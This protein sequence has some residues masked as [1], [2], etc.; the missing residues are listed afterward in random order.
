MQRFRQGFTLIELL[1]VMVIIALLVGLLLPALGRAR[2]EARKTQ[3]RSNLRQIGLAISMYTADNKSWTPALY[4]ISGDD[5]P[6]TWV[7]GGLR[8]WAN[9]Y[10]APATNCFNPVREGGI[11][12]TEVSP[13][14]YLV[15]NG[16]KD[17]AGRAQRPAMGN[18]LGLLFAGGYLTQQGGAVLDCPS[19]TMRADVSNVMNASRADLAAPFM[20]SGGKLLYANASRTAWMPG[21]GLPAMCTKLISHTS[22]YGSPNFGQDIL[23]GVNNSYRTAT[24]NN[25]PICTTTGSPA[26]YNTGAVATHPS[27]CFYLGSYALRITYNANDLSDTKPPSA[28]KLDEYQGKALAADSML[29]IRPELTFLPDSS[30]ERKPPSSQEGSFTELYSRL[31]TWFIGNHDQYWNV[32]M[33]DGS[34]KG[35]S[36]AGAAVAKEMF[37]NTIQ[38]PTSSTSMRYG[39]YW[40]GAPD[41]WGIRGTWHTPYT[42]NTRIWTAYFDPLYAQD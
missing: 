31:H 36:D 35:F 23:T 10:G 37:T 38:N 3:C 33:S 40:V 14:L 32:L 18:G 34:V 13:Q 27:Q 42:T 25:I 41:R 39:Y 12:V 30:N 20:T 1:V 21:D 29:M 2:E 15:P 17:N 9:D 19:R 8:Q 7:Y 5:S 4:G 16:N 22:A 24:F 6:A 11:G 28:M 26:L